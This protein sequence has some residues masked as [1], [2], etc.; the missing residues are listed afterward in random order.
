MKNCPETVSQTPFSGLDGFFLHHSSMDSSQSAEDDLP[1]DAHNRRPPVIAMVT[2][3]K[4]NKSFLMV[5]VSEALTKLVKQM[6]Q[7]T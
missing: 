5:V 4:R 7:Q 2:N 6:L 3:M 1:V